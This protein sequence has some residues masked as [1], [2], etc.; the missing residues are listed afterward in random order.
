MDDYYNKI[1]D[2]D[3][4]TESTLLAEYKPNNVW[5][6][7]TLFDL[8]NLNQLTWVKYA[9]NDNCL[10]NENCIALSLCRKYFECFQYLL[11]VYLERNVVFRL[12][13][14]FHPIRHSLMNEAIYNG[15]IRS[16]KMVYKLGYPYNFMSFI[17]A[18]FH[19]D[20][21]I[22]KFMVNTG[23]EWSE[24]T[25]TS[26]IN[27]GCSLQT[28]QL[29]LSLGCPLHHNSIYMALKLNVMDIVEC[30]YDYI[31]KH[32]ESHSFDLQI[33]T[34]NAISFLN[35]HPHSLF[36]NNYKPFEFCF[37]LATDKQQ[38]WKNEY[39]RVIHSVNL[40]SCVWR[41]LLDFNI[42][43]FD[44]ETRLIINNKKQHLCLLYNFTIYLLDT[45]IATDII[46]QVIN[47]MY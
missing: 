39:N 6:E 28:F 8:V 24:Q 14:T 23:C 36:P 11:P 31:Q 27:L 12:I 26:A 16:V 10:L 34:E 7:D 17:A 18:T 41:C 32:P 5:K 2:A 20:A 30:C 22:I 1:L 44:D 46:H 47:K 19:N 45:Y 21:D 35:D 25:T 29:Y 3:L 37:S 9:V 43:T 4:F 13:T 42:D 33:G 15:D 38:F 40:D